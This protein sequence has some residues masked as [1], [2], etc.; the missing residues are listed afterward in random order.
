MPFLTS[1]VISIRFSAT[2][3]YAFDIPYYH[4]FHMQSFTNSQFFTR[5]HTICGLH[6]SSFKHQ[7]PPFAER[8]D[9]ADGHLT[10][11]ITLA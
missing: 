4:L 1:D 8:F 3:K 11:A 2:P 7:P 9:R 6:A 5:S 10:A